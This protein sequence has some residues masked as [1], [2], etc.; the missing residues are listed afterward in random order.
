[1]RDGVR[2][3]RRAVRPAVRVWEMLAG[4]DPQVRDP[5]GRTLTTW[6]VSGPEPG[7]A[8]QLP[9]PGSPW[10]GLAAGTPQLPALS[11]S[12]P[13]GPLELTWL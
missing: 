13:A 8:A 10:Q 6:R 1:M 2:R 4:A 3:D 5:V 12:L 11:Q 7:R 9:G